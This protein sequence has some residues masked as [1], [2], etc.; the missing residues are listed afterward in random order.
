[1]T[2]DLEARLLASVP[3]VGHFQRLEELG[4]VEGSFQHYGP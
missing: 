1:M 2:K 3:S 4:I